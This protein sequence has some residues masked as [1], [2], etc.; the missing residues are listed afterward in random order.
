MNGARFVR[1]IAVV[2]KLYGGY[3]S[4]IAVIE[5]M[6]EIQQRQKPYCIAVYVTAGKVNKTLIGLTYR[7]RYFSSVFV[8]K[9][10]LWRYESIGMF[11]WLVTTEDVFVTRSVPCMDFLISDFRELFVS[12]SS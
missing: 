3:G 11:G 5:A 10:S 4:I 2:P 12:T 1:P 6:A 9:R 7:S 8:M